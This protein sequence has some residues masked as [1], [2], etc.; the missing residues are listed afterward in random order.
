MNE[1]V[2]VHVEKKSGK[3]RGKRGRRIEYAGSTKETNSDCLSVSNYNTKQKGTRGQKRNRRNRR[4][5]RH[6]KAKVT[7]KASQLPDLRDELAR[8]RLR[9]ENVVR[10]EVSVN[11]R[12]RPTVQVQHPISDIKSN[13]QLG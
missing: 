3:D 2:Y 11:D 8:R 6:N 5:R 12:T 7:N 10:F 13:R 4:N 1:R 9:D